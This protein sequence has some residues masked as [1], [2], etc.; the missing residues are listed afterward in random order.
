MRLL[1][2]LPAVGDL[3]NTCIRTVGTYAHWFSS[4]AEL[5]PQML[6]YVS[7]GLTQ[8]AMAAAAAQSMK[9]LCDAC[10]EHL[11]DDT[12]GRELHGEGVQSGCT[13]RTVADSYEHW[14]RLE[15]AAPLR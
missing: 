2:T 3:Q 9:Q 15:L 1:P 4:N 12:S 13:A 8:E 10:S 6:Q 5:L 14:M 7:Q 11:S